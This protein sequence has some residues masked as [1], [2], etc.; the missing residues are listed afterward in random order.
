MASKTLG[1]F[2]TLLNYDN[3]I[4][5][6]HLNIVPIFYLS[7]PLVIF[8]FA[9]LAAVITAK[10]YLWAPNRTKNAPIVHF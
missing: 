9:N 2:I 3:N 8:K 4:N 7:L 1:K 10:H 5:D 6:T